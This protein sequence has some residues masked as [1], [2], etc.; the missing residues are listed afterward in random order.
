MSSTQTRSRRTFL[1]LVALGSGISRRDPTTFTKGDEWNVY[2][3]AGEG[4]GL[5][6]RYRL[7]GVRENAF[8][9]TVVDTEFVRF[10]G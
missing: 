8:D 4:I 2:Y 6:I 1:S 7:L 5:R 3:S 10:D 9:V